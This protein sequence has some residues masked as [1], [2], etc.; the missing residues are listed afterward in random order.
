MLATLFFPSFSFFIFLYLFVFLIYELVFL[1]Y[2]V[3]LSEVASKHNHV[4]GCDA[5]VVLMIE[6]QTLVANGCNSK[7]FLCNWHYVEDEGQI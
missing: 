6:G 3:T 5:T 1:F 4:P 7:A 2:F